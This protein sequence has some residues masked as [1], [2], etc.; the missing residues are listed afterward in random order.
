ML[1][2]YGNDFHDTE[3]HLDH[4]V[5]KGYEEEISVL[6][7]R[8]ISSLERDVL[9]RIYIYFEPAGFNKLPHFSTA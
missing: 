3:I 4:C 5:D 1:W 7:C 9:L 2:Q 6:L 8:G